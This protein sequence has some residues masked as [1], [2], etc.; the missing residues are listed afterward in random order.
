MRLYRI[1]TLDMYEIH[2][3][4]HGLRFG[5]EVDYKNRCVR[6]TGETVPSDD[7]NRSRFVIPLTGRHLSTNLRCIWWWTKTGARDIPLGME[8]GARGSYCLLKLETQLHQHVASVVCSLPNLLSAY[9][10]GLIHISASSH[11]TFKHTQTP[12]QWYA[13]PPRRSSPD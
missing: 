8:L 10:F 9:Q 11:I 4:L 1:G 13:T 3:L 5:S 7:T 2:H 6:T 12:P